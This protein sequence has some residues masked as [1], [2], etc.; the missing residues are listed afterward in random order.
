MHLFRKV[1]QFSSFFRKCPWL[2][3]AENEPVRSKLWSFYNIACKLTCIRLHV[4]PTSV[5]SGAPDVKQAPP[6]DICWRTVPKLFYRL[7]GNCQHTML[8]PERS[9]E[10][11]HFPFGRRDVL[12]PIPEKHGKEHAADGRLSF[13]QSTVPVECVTSCLLLRLWCAVSL[14]VHRDR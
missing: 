1:Q 14:R 3:K 13:A 9:M 6:V 10:F 2:L 7:K 8:R 12:S 5:R 4:L 11:R